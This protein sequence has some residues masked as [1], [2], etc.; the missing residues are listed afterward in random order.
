MTDYLEQLLDGAQALSRAVQAAE[1][2]HAV[3]ARGGETAEETDALAP[4]GRQMGEMEF[5]AAEVL[6]RSVTLPAAA[7]E[8]PES[9]GG[10]PALWEEERT[11]L[12]ILR[13]V[14]QGERTAQ[15]HSG[16]AQPGH[17]SGEGTEPS[18][19]AAPAMA[20]QLEAQAVDL[21]FQRDSRRYDN[22]FSLF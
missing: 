18:R 1:G 2:A 16:A 21:A 3:G 17:G 6:R 15:I 9:G 4:A 10:A 13:A 8:G 22:G 14:E 5:L 12:P 19:S 11:P 7:E 20:G